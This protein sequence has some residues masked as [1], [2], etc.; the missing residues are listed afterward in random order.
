MSGEAPPEPLHS[1]FQKLVD[2][3]AA[4]EANGAPRWEQLSVQELRAHTKDLRKTTQ[5]VLGVATRNMKIALA[6]VCLQA[7]LYIPDGAPEVGPGLVYFHGGGFTIG[8]VE[9]HDAV[10]AQLARASGVRIL[11]VDYRLAPEFRFPTAHDDALGSVRWV[12]DNAGSIGFDRERIAVGGDSAG[13]NLAASACLDLRG[14][15]SRSVR[16]LL[17]LYPNLTIDGT[18][19]SRARYSKGYY[20]TLAAAHHLFGQ[21]VRGT[22]EAR[23]PR[24]DLLRRTDLEGLPPSHLAVGTCDILYDECVVFTDHLAAA[25][26]PITLSCYPGFIHGF[27]GFAHRV[28][29]VRRAFEVTGDALAAG[30]E[31]EGRSMSAFAMQSASPRVRNQPTP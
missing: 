3:L 31:F 29:A 22:S 2:E 30:L 8:S 20:L 13:A 28:V 27:F 24:I 26:V 10:V 25:E 21:Y 9:T 5:P 14:D 6:D 19:G 1:D 4:A 15:P 17:L 23:N 11:S 7:R 18:S 12:F 16:F